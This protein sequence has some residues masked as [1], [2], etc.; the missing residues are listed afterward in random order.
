MRIG[1]DVSQMCY[2]GTGVARYVY[3]LTEALLNLDTNHLFVLYAG[4]LRQRDFFEKLKTQ[5]PWD[6]A[7]WHILPI[8]PKVAGLALNTLPIHIEWQ[9]S[10]VSESI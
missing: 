10:L 4:A 7:E 6:K 1:I 8:P 3:G 5:S 2:E 9:K